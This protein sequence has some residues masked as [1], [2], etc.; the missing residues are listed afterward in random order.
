[1]EKQ[2]HKK[3]H[4][5]CHSHKYVDISSSHTYLDANFNLISLHRTSFLLNSCQLISALESCALQPNS[6]KLICRMHFWV[7]KCSIMQII[8]QFHSAKTLH[9]VCH[10]LITWS[11]SR[12]VASLA[13]MYQ[14]SAMQGS[15]MTLKWPFVSFSLTSVGW[16]Q[17]LLNQWLSLEWLLEVAAQTARPF[18]QGTLWY[19]QRFLFIG[20]HSYQYWL[21]GNCGWVGNSHRYAL[22]ITDARCNT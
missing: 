20:A 22:L 16:G 11:S 21:I 9:F 8:L 6:G 14:L 3:L 19:Y 15:A 5:V 2:F 7:T 17:I 12:A 18:L 4:F 1:M 13:K 10:T